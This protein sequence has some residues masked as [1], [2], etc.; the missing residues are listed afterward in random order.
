M[1]HIIAIADTGGERPAYSCLSH[2]NALEPLCVPH[3]LRQTAMQLALRKRWPTQTREE[4]I[5]EDEAELLITNT[6]GALKTNGHPCTRWVDPGTKCHK[7][8]VTR[9]RTSGRLGEN[10]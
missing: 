1:N 8:G 6:C 3:H 9:L 10:W 7:H 5:A 4:I 2:Q